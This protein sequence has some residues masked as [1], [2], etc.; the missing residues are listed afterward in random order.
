MEKKKAVIYCRTTTL[1]SESQKAYYIGKINENPD[2]ELVGVFIDF[3]VPGKN[4]KNQVEFKKVI[5]LCEQGK[6]DMII[7]KSPSNFTRNINE[8]LKYIKK[9]KEYKV[10]VFFENL[11]IHSEDEIFEQCMK[12]LEKI[13][14]EESSKKQWNSKKLK[15]TY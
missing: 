12:M 6:V 9:I 3:Y 2:L 7:T 14:I 10:D 15:K 8:L 13:T 4:A 11:S 5:Q 1:W